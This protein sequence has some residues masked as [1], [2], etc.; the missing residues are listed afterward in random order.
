MSLPHRITIEISDALFSEISEFKKVQAIEDDTIAICRLIKN[1]L[2]IPEY[3]RD[4]DW[5]VAEKEAD[6]DIKTGRTKGF[7]TVDELL[8]DL[9]A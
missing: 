9:N 8:A 2:S 3:F 1:G 5:Q 4:F 7:S 6:E